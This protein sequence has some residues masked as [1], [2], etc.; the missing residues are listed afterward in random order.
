MRKEL[1]IVLSAAPPP[2]PAEL[3]VTAQLFSVPE[4]APPPPPHTE[5]C[6]ILAMVSVPP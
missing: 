5:L 3:S 6:S 4:N 1:L 2:A